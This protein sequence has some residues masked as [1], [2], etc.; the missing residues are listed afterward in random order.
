MGVAMSALAQSGL[1]LIAG[2]IVFRTVLVGGHVNYVRPGLGIPL[3]LA[4]AVLVLVG[5]ASLWSKVAAGEGSAR[6][7]VIVNGHHGPRV[8]WLLLAPL[9]ALITIPQIPLGSYAAGLGAGR[10]PVRASVDF[11]PL[12][13][14]ETPIDLPLS[15]FVGR[16]LYAPE[17]LEGRLVRMV[18][19]VTPDTDAPS[20]WLLT[21][22]SIG[23]CAAD[24]FPL[25]V[26]VL[27]E[28]SRDADEWVEVVG[29]YRPSPVQ[30]A[31]DSG[32]PQL[33]VVQARSVPQPDNP[34]EY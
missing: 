10:S 4:A 14:A 15:Q 22:F 19:F 18:G 24:A 1:M 9:L 25:K 23:C 34:Y 6:E 17:T 7:V 28:V 29:V 11:P 30:G 31:D 32:P 3:L 26:A 20:G 12:P 21:R 2:V 16:A 27:N 33:G 8:G 13:E 5:V